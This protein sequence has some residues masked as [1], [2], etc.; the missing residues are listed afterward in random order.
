MQISITDITIDSAVQPR[1]RMDQITIDEYSARMRDGDTFPALIVYREEGADRYILADGFHRYYAARQAGYESVE[2]EERVGGQA[3]AVWHACSANKAHGLRR[4]NDD[5]R[6]A[7]MLAAQSEASLTMSN[8]AIADYVGVSEGL[9]RS[10][11]DSLGESPTEVV[12]RDGVVRNVERQRASVIHSTDTSSDEVA[13]D[14][15]P[16]PG[17]VF[18]RYGTVIPE[19]IQPTWERAIREVR[20]H[21]QALVSVRSRVAES[22]DES[23]SSGGVTYATCND[24]VYA[25]LPYVPFKVDINNAVRALERACKPESVCP[26]CRGGRSRSNCE[27]CLGRGWMS[28]TQLTTVPEELRP[29]E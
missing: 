15:T 8:R 7:T 17:P 4:T 22:F 29:T 5:K 3:A 24:P 26:Y 13:P 20:E 27:P 19:Q 10:V 18:D 25:G 1:V 14:P 28:S 12:G 21:K 11:R 9:V 23:G 6:R 16:E 2:V